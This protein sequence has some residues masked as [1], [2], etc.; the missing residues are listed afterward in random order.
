MHLKQE[1]LDRRLMNVD[2]FVIEEMAELDR[3]AKTKLE[4]RFKIALA[5]LP[6][7]L[8]ETAM[9][10][11]MQL[12]HAEYPDYRFDPTRHPKFYEI[13]DIVLSYLAVILPEMVKPF[14]EDPRLE[15]EDDSER[16]HVVNTIKTRSEC[17][18]LLHVSFEKK[19]AAIFGKLEHALIPMGNHNQ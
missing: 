16:Q 18:I 3:P 10:F 11:T 1:K 19:H 14:E 15:C 9:D 6:Q 17:I 13:G 5:T 12:F 8:Q 7:E 4:V 2:A